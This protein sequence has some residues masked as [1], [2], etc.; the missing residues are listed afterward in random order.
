MENLG[1]ETWNR[2]K[3]YTYLLCFSEKCGEEGGESKKEKASVPEMLWETSGRQ[4]TEQLELSSQRKTPETRPQIRSLEKVVAKEEMPHSDDRTADK[5]CLPPNRQGM[6][7]PVFA[8][9]LPWFP[10]SFIFQKINCLS[11]WDLGI[12]F[13]E[14]S[15]TLTCKL[16]CNN[17]CN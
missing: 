10:L 14:L 17:Y 12:H 16:S 4:R 2:L 5:L 3:A 13:E 9:L 7:V 1:V 11:A 8:G 15:S 6:S